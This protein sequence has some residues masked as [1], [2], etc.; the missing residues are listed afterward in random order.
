MAVV[1]GAREYNKGMRE[2]KQDCS[3]VWNIQPGA[4]RAGEAGEG[5]CN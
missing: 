1:I 2:N 5:A 4:H 3:P